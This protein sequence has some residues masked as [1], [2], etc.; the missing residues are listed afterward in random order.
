MDMCRFIGSEDMEYQKVAAA[1]LRIIEAIG[2]NSSAN[3]NNTQ[4][5]W[6]LNLEQKKALLD[7]L[8][9]TQLDTRRLTIKNA[10]RKTCQWFLQQSEYLNWFSSEKL[11]NDHGF[12]WIKGH[13]GTGKSTLMKFLLANARKTTKG[14]GTTILSFFFNARGEEL[15]KTT[16][17]TYRSLLFQLLQQIPEL[18]SIFDSD[19]I[20]PWM[21]TPQFQWSVEVL[22]ELFELAI[23]SLGQHSVI[24]FI[25][26]IDECNENHVQDMVSYF[27]DLDNLVVSE[28]IDFRICL[29]SRHY[30]HINLSV[31]LSLDLERQ[32]GH[33]Q[34]IVDYIDSELKIGPAL[35]AERIKTEVRRK[36]SGVFMWVILVIEI[37]NKSYSKGRIRDLERKL[38]EIP[39]DLHKLFRS[40]LTRDSAHKDEMV[41]CMQWI[42]FA[43]QPLSPEGLYFAVLSGIEDSELGIWD[44]DMLTIDDIHRCIVDLSKG[45]AEV[46]KL[47]SPTVQ[48]IHES[49]RDYLLKD[50]GLRELLDHSAPN[51]LGLSYDRLKWC[52]YRYI[53]MVPWDQS[54]FF[55]VPGKEVAKRKEDVN[56]AYPFIQ[57]A[58]Q[59]MLLLANRADGEGFSQENFVRDCESKHL[60]L[61][62][63]SNLFEK[64]FVRRHPPE[65]S[66]LY[67]LANGHFE[68]LIKH[69]RKSQDYTESGPGRY[70]TPLLAALATQSYSVV[71]ELLRLRSQ[72]LPFDHPSRILFEKQ[73][74]ETRWSGSLGRTMTL[75]KERDVASYLVEHGNR[76]LVSFYL[77]AEDIDVN[78]H[79]KS[80]YCLFHYVRETDD[81][82]FEN[83][84]TNQGAVINCKCG[85]FNSYAS[86]RIFG[87]CKNS[88]IHLVQICL[89]NGID[90][91]LHIKGEALVWVAAREGHLGVIDLLLSRGSDIEA[92]NN[93]G[94][95]LLSWVTARRRETI[96]KLLVDAG[97]N[98]NSKDKNGRTPLV[99]AAVNRHEAIVKLLIDACA[100]VDLKDKSGWA[101][102]TWA[103][104]SG[105]EAVV[106]LLLGTGKVDVD[107]K[108]S[109]GGTP[110]W[111]AVDSG[112]EAI[113]KLL[114]D[115]CADVDLKNKDGCTP[116]MLAVWSGYEAIVKLLIDTGKVDV[117][118]KDKAGDT[119]L[120]RAAES[121]HKAILR[122]LKSTTSSHSLPL[123]HP[124]PHHS[125]SLT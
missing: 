26:A 91:N 49:V 77:N 29:S 121:G 73:S 104:W 107:S 102:L 5:I 17:G 14:K 19:T 110:L 44:Q 15:E 114:V 11:S 45:L 10:H 6:L 115:A 24:C 74:D 52:C 18:Q 2:S 13:P 28:N 12:L 85:S 42:L 50:K 27:E 31:A 47:T 79:D 37:L 56:N 101:P 20:S 124:R 95:T 92:P 7:S 97:A 125:A 51:T 46:T 98:V 68:N 48:F 63:Y 113:V 41:L 89:N 1:I 53:H 93:D 65:V 25:D 33:D 84:V 116:L 60:R 105:N 122:L 66:F 57:Y 54:T 9:F 117:N 82:M 99:W 72:V 22:K 58:A 8:W 100:D 35:Q 118:S 86:K 80:G 34:D 123:P 59:N 61:I 111:R 120:S 94:E 21:C 76:P 103:A 3:N 109:F 83:L 96:V 69:L 108:D 16:V 43:E 32:E 106:K 75:S 62:S 38:Q 81:A 71:Q 4:N 88:H 67:F 30:P 36:A 23:R 64:H 119:P 39:D 78:S 40:L 70:R 87:F 90:A 112:H 55:N